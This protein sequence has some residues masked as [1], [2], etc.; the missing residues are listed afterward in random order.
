MSKKS[1]VKPVAFGVAAV[2]GAIFCLNAYTVVQDGSVK[3]KTF[4]GKVDSAPLTPGFHF[5]VN[6]FASFDTYSTRDIK[7]TYKDIQV[8]SQDKF[9]TSVDVTLMVRFNGA[10]APAVRIDGGSEEQSI[11]KYIDQKF[12]S[13]VREFGKGVKTAQD[14]FKSDVQAGLQTSIL[15]EVN[16]YSQKFG[17]TITEVFIQDVELDPVIKEQIVNTKAREEKVFQ[18]QADLDRVEKVS[19]QKVKQAEADRE[20]RDN[21]ARAN[22]RDADAKLYAARKEA[23]ANNALQRTITP[24]MTK[25]KQ[26]DVEMLRATKYQGG[27]PQT[28]VGAGYDGQM[29]MDMRNK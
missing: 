15:A 13:T 21:D 12:M 19:Q 8:P 11:D 3:T 22:E 2:L 25:W 6:P 23:E 27:V 10:K 16:E 5:P 9:K 20:A 18:A 4:L 14:L 26:L 1:I 24:E 7:L 17:Y 28:V 29:L